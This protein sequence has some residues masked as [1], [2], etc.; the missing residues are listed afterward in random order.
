[1][2]AE[3]YVRDEGNISDLYH[4]SPLRGSLM[5]TVGA[6]RPGGGV[7]GICALFEI[8]VV[9]IIIILSGLAVVDNL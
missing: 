8:T 1:M 4:F 7:L 5:F 3:E 9:V 6:C 2:R